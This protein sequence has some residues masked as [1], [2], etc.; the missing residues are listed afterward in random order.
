MN[1][2]YYQKNIR[3][4]QADSPDPVVH[5][6][7]A[8]FTKDYRFN[9]EWEPDNQ[10]LLKSRIELKETGEGLGGKPMGFL[11]YQDA[12]VK[13]TRWPLTVTMRYA[14]FD[15]PDYDSRIY[16]YEPEVLYGYSVPAYEG[17]GMRFCLVLHTQI[18]RNFNIWVRGGL[19]YYEGRNSIGTGLDQTPGNSRFEFTGQLMVRL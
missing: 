16:V 4:N 1:F 15:I 13:L 12:R 18:G 5:K 19:T 2:R 3:R 10:L 17:K 9:L 7:T 14:L 6:L 8:C 11:I